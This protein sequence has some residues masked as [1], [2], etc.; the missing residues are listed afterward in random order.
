MRNSQQAWAAVLPD[1]RYD[2][3]AGQTHN[4]GTEV[5]APVLAEFF[6]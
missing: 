2:T 1:A 6:S 4:V 3:L 5:L